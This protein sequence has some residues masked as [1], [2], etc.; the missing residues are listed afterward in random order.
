M[1]ITFEG[2]EACGKSTQ[3]KLLAD[4]LTEQ[5]EDVF[6]TKEPGS[7]SDP[8]CQKIRAL[9]LDPENSIDHRAAFFLFLADRSQHMNQIKEVIGRGGYVISDRSS[10]ST[11]VYYLAGIKQDTLYP[12]LDQVEP[13]LSYAQQMSPDVCF[14]C[15]ADY[16]WCEERLIERGGKDRIEQFDGGFHQ[17]V[18]GLFEEYA[19][20]WEGYTPHGTW[21]TFAP[22]HTVKAPK[23]SESSITDIHHFIKLQVAEIWQER[24][25]RILV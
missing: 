1:Y 3:A 24:Q 7:P 4:Y 10:L 15:S 22:N 12:V 16:D 25:D 18:H 21:A 19:Q 6:L 2:P 23:A 13:M 5:G 20:T 14:M 9:L 11:L 17:R 8:V